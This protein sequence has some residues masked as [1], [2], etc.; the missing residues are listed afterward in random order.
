V[1]VVAVRLAAN[2]GGGRRTRVDGG[3]VAVVVLV[4]VMVIVVVMVL[5]AGGRSL[6]G[7]GAL[8]VP[9]ITVGLAADGG[10]R[11]RAG[12]DGG[13]IVAG[14]GGLRGSRALTMPVVTVRLTA[15]GSCGRRAGVL[16]GGGGNEAEDGEDLSSLHFDGCV[17][18]GGSQKLRWNTGKVPCERILRDLTSVKCE[19][20]SE[21]RQTVSCELRA[22]FYRCSLD[23]SQ[24]KRSHS[25]C[26]LRGDS[27]RSEIGRRLNPVFEGGERVDGRRFQLVMVG[28]RPKR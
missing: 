12:V 18:L 15:D 13:V 7:S 5:L 21:D 3:A 4:V 20:R 14:G 28:C 6:G 26:Q 8:A 22:M 27:T 10:G 17:V 1:P 19:D 9:V 23:A 25:P 24:E 11:R 2:R 16:G